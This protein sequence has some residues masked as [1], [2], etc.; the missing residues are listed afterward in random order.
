VGTITVI[1]LNLLYLKYA[2]N[3]SEKKGETYYNMKNPDGLTENVDKYEGK[4]L[5]PLILSVIPP[6]FLL[7]MLNI[8]KLEVVYTLMLTVILSS[9][10]F[11]KFIENKLT[12]VNVGATNTVLPLVNTS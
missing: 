10:V 2:L 3:K 6:L 8:V 11:W 1:V 5:P 4:R 12:T 7:I 9:I